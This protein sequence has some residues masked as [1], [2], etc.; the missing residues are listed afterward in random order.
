LTAVVVPIT[1]I[2]DADIF[3]TLSKINEENDYLGNDW[4]WL[5]L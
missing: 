1:T 4:W 5:V 2:A 3:I